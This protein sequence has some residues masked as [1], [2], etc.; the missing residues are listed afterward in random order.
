[1]QH[2]SSG[3]GLWLHGRNC[4]RVVGQSIAWR[5]RIAVRSLLVSV[6][7][8]KVKWKLMM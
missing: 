7:S 2:G 5:R 8:V 6:R 3:L 1:M 4:R